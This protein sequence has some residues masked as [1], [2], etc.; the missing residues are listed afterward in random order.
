MFIFTVFGIPSVKN[1]NRKYR[2]IEMKKRLTITAAVLAIFVMVFAALA[3]AQADKTTPPARPFYGSGYGPGGCVWGANAPLKLT[4]DQQEKLADLMRKNVVDKYKIR[5]EM[6]LKR[7][8][9]MTLYQADKPNL[10]KIDSL[11][12]SIRDLRDKE[13]DLKR[14]FRDSARKLLTKEQ[15]DENPYAF[16]KRGRG[17]GGSY[18]MGPGAGSGMGSGMGYYGKGRGGKGGFGGMSFPRW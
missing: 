2:R 4:A 14:K 7:I 13:F 9:L 3:F 18:G 15:L 10:K 5:T 12:D 16:C 1:L 17:F 6:Q 11:E 8:E